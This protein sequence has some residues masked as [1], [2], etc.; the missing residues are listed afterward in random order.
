[1]V[2]VVVGK[3]GFEAAMRKFRKK[4]SESGVLKDVRDKEFYE[5][6]SEVRRKKHKA[7]IAR[8]KREI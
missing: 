4:I 7:A 1:M 6:P 3:G 2:S 5:K 8:Q